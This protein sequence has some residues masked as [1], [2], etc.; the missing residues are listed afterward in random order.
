MKE[1]L[2]I[3]RDRFSGY[4]EDIVN[5]FNIDLNSWTN[6][7]TRIKARIYIELSIPI[8][9]I[10]LKLKIG[11]NAMTSLYITVCLTGILLQFTATPTLWHIG[12]LLF[13]LSST[14]DWVDGFLARHHGTA[15]DYG[16]KLD[17]SAGEIHI[18]AFMTTLTLWV[19]NITENPIYPQISA[20]LVFLFLTLKILNT[21]ST[22]QPYS[23]TSNREKYK[24]KHTFLSKEFIYKI[25]IYD[26]RS[27][28]T[29]LL[30]LL[31]IIYY[32]YPQI[33][34][35]IYIPFY[36]AFLYSFILMKKL[37]FIAQLKM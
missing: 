26:G 14:L 2:K 19:G 15:S 4:K 24:N 9:Y 10:A 35:S 33:F 21:I 30:I 32:L 12:L 7:Y 28:Y 36:W 31:C 37:L 8:I 13:F 5:N 17:E 22:Q 3:R 27:R 23:L 25:I 29:D 1:Y 11:A 6:P 16:A 18:Y 34:F 20:I